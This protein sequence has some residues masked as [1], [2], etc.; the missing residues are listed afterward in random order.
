MIAS[1]VVKM[2]FVVMRVL[3]LTSK[4]M[5]ILVLDFNFKSNLSWKQLKYFQI[6]P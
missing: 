3:L 4:L 6:Y 5:K 1:F 2:L